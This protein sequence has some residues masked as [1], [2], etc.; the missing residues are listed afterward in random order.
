[1]IDPTPRAAARHGR[2]RLWVL[3][4]VLGTLL[5]FLL[6]NM[7]VTRIRFLLWSWDLPAAA[8]VLLW[9]GMGA[10]V[11]WL[12]HTLHGIRRR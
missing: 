2:T 8:M 11:G 4:T 1:M 5:L 6:Q 10:A 7:A 9:F 3:V 12:L